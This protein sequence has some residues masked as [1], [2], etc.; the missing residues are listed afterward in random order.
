MLTV[1]SIGV[2]TNATTSLRLVAI[3]CNL[4]PIV[5][6]PFTSD[7]EKS[8]FTSTVSASPNNSRPVVISPLVLVV[9]STPPD[10]SY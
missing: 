10:K 1:S 4:F 3:V 8:R 7:S 2:P 9:A 5:L 6:S